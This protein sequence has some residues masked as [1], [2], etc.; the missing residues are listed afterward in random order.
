[1]PGQPPH[2]IGALA[3]KL[4]GGGSAINGAISRRA[5]PSDFARWQ[6]RGLENWGW[7]DVLPVFKS[8]EN[9]PAGSDQWHGRSGPW[10]IRQ[11]ELDKVNPVSQ[12]FVHAAMAGLRVHR[13]LQRSQTAR[14]RAR[15]AKHG[16][17]RSLQC[18]GDLLERTRPRT[19]EPR[20]TRT[21]Q[22]HG[23]A[24]HALLRDF[25]TL[26]AGAAC[27]REG[28]S[29]Y[30]VAALDRTVVERGHAP[31]T[32]W[33][34]ELPIYP[35]TTIALFV[36][37]SFLSMSHGS[38]AMFVLMLV[39]SIAAGFACFVRGSL[40]ADVPPLVR[41][42]LFAFLLASGESRFALLLGNPILLAVALL[43]FCCLDTAPSRRN[44]RVVLFSLAC[45]LKP[46]IALPFLLP[47]L[48]KPAD[49]WRTVLRAVGC[50]AAFTAAVLAWCAVH[51]A[52]AGWV[53]DLHR[54]V[55]AG[56]GA[57]QL[58]GPGRAQPCAGHPAER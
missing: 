26:D 54:E 9:T 19:Q 30:D 53:T 42:L 55:D 27:L 47:L 50:M 22:S 48:V 49:G 10:P 8:L 38:E 58:H 4:L 40:L 35:P 20:D 52:T 36:P 12:A 14:R 11:P 28:C 34:L 39:V 23:L 57:R 25:A 13:R 43:L 41:A 37:F 33:P 6:S 5:R 46:Q 31:L 29:P 45:L 2:I 18:W 44:L 3:G 51:P 32:N 17:R 1:M 56:R 15:A 21:R 16:E 24:P 7:D